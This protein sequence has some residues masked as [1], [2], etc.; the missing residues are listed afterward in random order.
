[1]A[2]GVSCDRLPSRSFVHTL[3]V[4]TTSGSTIVG[5]AR[6]FIQRI[7]DSHDRVLLLPQVRMEG[8]W[9]TLTKEL[10]IY[11]RIPSAEYRDQ[12]RNRQRAHQAA[13]RL[14][15]APIRVSLN[16]EA[17]RELSRV[18]LLAH[19]AGPD[20]P[21]TWATLASVEKPRIESDL[22]T[23]ESGDP[24]AVLAILTRA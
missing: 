11:R 23:L 20:H 15:S 19:Q 2:A 14:Y 1:M 7:G 6:R 12:C 4:E 24:R 5:A 8:K 17:L 10:G 18:E 13:L 22:D 9:V 3:T 21:A 16:C